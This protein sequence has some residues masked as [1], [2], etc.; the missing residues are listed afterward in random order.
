[1]SPNAAL[2]APAW[3]PDG[4]RLAFA[5]VVEPD[6]PGQPAQQDIW[7]IHADGTN[8][9]RLTDARAQHATPFWAADGRVYFISN[10]GGKDA[11]WSTRADGP[12]QSTAAIDAGPAGR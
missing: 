9:A 6:A 4:M 3:A 2:V 5:T 7:T 8:R 11:I 12:R 1:M 10:R